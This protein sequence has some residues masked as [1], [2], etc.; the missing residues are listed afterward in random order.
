MGYF[1]KLTNGM[2]E[3]VIS[4]SNYDLGEPASSF[5]QTEQA[6]RDFISNIL[7]LD[8]EWLQTSYNATFRKNYAGIGFFYDYIKD[9]FIPPKPF[10]S[11]LL[12]DETCRWI[13]PV[14]YPNDGKAYIWDESITSWKEITQ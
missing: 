1:A 11:W 9:A 3:K 10:T 4:V 2:V 13:A 6:G 12:D 14:A 5:P 7:G 8:G